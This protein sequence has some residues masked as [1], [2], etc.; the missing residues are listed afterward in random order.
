[1]KK[2]IIFLFIVLSVILTACKNEEPIDKTMKEEDN[3]L[4][5]KVS[6]V[7]KE[8]HLLFTTSFE[9]T[10]QKSMPLIL[11]GQSMKII[12]NGKQYPTVIKGAAFE[13]TL[14]KNETFKT[15]TL[16]I[17]LDKAKGKATIIVSYQ[18][19]GKEK[20]IHFPMNLQESK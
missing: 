15:E 10:L 3:G 19:E 8:N 13:K 11:G 2:K 20:E 16:T 14:K 17:P 6:A 9:N 7:E 18:E 12:T 4:L 5:I 1:M